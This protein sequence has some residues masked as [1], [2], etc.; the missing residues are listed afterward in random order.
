MLI[1][2]SLDMFGH[3][4]RKLSVSLCISTFLQT[5]Q[6]THSKINYCAEWITS[7]TTAAI[8]QRKSLI[9][10]LRD[11]VTVLRPRP[12]VQW[13]IL[14]ASQPQLKLIPEKQKRRVQSD[15]ISKLCDLH[16]NDWHCKHEACCQQ[17]IRSWKGSVWETASYQEG[18]EYKSTCTSRPWQRISHY[19]CCRTT[20]RVPALCTS[21]QPSQNRMGQKEKVTCLLYS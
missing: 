15:G 14:S 13:P 6:K 21:L 9:P 12:P 3:E 19:L 7:S 2:M 10:Q 20:Q 17:D 8:L 18:G 16:N 5:T 1:Q 4:T 11:W